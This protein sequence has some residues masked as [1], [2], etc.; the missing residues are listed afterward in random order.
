MGY[1]GDIHRRDTNVQ[2]EVQYVVLPNGGIHKVHIGENRDGEAID[3]VC[4]A[5]DICWAGSDVHY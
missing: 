3:A 1:F 4:E 2:I 5:I